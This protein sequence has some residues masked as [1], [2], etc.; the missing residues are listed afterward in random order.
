MNLILALLLAWLAVVAGLLVAWRSSLLALWR[1]P[2]FK[3]PVLIVE[4][5]DWGAGPLAQADAL[6]AIAAV[7]A[8]HRDK[9]GRHPVMTLALVLAIPK[10]GMASLETLA[11]ESQRANL[12]AILAGREQGVFALQLHGMTHFWP[13]AV[14]ATAQVRE[15][16]RSW[17]VE[18]IL[19]ERLPSH[20]QSRWINAAELPSQPLDPEKV[21]KAVHDETSCFAGLFGGV[22]EVV[23]P[24]TFV[25]T[26]DVEA[27]WAAQ[28]VRVVITPGCRFTMRDAQGLPAGIDRR[29]LNG[30][31]GAGEA[32]YLVR[33]DYFEPMLGHRSEHALAALS[34]KSA[35]G[36]PCLLE[37]HRSNFLAEAGGNPEASIGELD[38]LYSLALR[39]FPDLRFVSSA[40]LGRAMR[41]GDSVWIEQHHGRR[42]ATW[43]RRAAKLP[44]F[45]KL[46]RL[47]GLFAFLKLYERSLGYFK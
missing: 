13:D 32:R 25:W 26:Q 36:R 4:S 43:L 12:D 39:T 3:F 34:D 33:D 20:L 40:E 17:Q 14:I 38:K 8:R 31:Q 7:L 28:G 24:P 41:T 27:A 23:V 29:M 18:P 47:V 16:V 44:R 2:V 30:G 11:D 37:T 10:P 45:G 35:L 1:E 6:G 21:N 19:T 22:P 5:D 9:V 42:F 46:A 15:D